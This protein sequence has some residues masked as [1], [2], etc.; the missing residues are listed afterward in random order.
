MTYSTGTISSRVS[1]TT[2][3]PPPTFFVDRLFE[4]VER[5]RKSIGVAMSGT[6][7]PSNHPQH[8]V[9]FDEASR[10]SALC[11]AFGGY[12]QSRDRRASSLRA[13]RSG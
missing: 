12:E 11:C 13:L 5:A 10:R 7:S 9:G 8:D 2:R 3:L 4:I 1:S 6:A